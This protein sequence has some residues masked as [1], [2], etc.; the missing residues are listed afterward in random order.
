MDIR[1]LSK[2]TKI[3]S[4]SNRTE[5]IH[6]HG[7]EFTYESPLLFYNTIRVN[8]DLRKSKTGLYVEF[9][10]P[11][12]LCR[13]IGFKNFYILNQIY[14]FDPTITINEKST[15]LFSTKSIEDLDILVDAII[16]AY[17]GKVINS[18][19]TT[20]YIN[21]RLHNN[22]CITMYFSYVYDE[23]EDSNDGYIIEIIHEQTTLYKEQFKAFVV[24]FT[25]LIED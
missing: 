19:R 21:F 3:F 10:D 4:G 25:K 6:I 7:I 24:D 1:E 13:T 5:N 22:C 8:A 11:T 16:H 2:H 15:V 20:D 18:N 12:T 23:E 9:N 14:K 17:N